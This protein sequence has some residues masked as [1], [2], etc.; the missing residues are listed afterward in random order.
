MLVDW[1]GLPPHEASVTLSK[2]G[3]PLR[4]ELDNYD[5]VADSLAGSGFEWMLG[6]GKTAPEK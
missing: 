4:K 2:T 3:S 5:Q 6:E 1:C